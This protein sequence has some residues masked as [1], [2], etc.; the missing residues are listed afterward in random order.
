MSVRT[1]SAMAS[2][3]L[4]AAAAAGQMLNVNVT[5]RD[6]MSSHPDMEP[7][8]LAAFLAGFQNTPVTG[9]VEDMLGPD[10]KPVYTGNIPGSALANGLFTNGSNFDQWYRDVPGVNQRIESQLT[11][12]ETDDPGV[13]QFDS[14]PGFFPLD[15]MGFGNEGNPHNQHF[16]LEMRTK[17]TYQ[18]G[19]FF[20]FAGDDDLW[21]FINGKLAIDLGGI[22]STV[23]DTVLLDNIAADFGL[24]I[25]ETYSFDLFFAERQ[26]IESNF[27]ATTSI[28]LRVPTPA[29]AGVLGLAGLMAGRRR[30]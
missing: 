14:G 3:A 21:V 16:T 1:H 13:F 29:T 10:G 2:V 8:Q 9:V 5:Y 23:N 15:G 26:T 6:F 25:G 17:F 20:E 18:G 24:E 27:K 7:G 12:T 4:I 11:F 28:E 30:R 22:H 19:E